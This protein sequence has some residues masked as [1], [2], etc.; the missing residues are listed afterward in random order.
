MKTGNLPKHG[1]ILTRNN[2]NY[3]YNKHS[4]AYICD[5]DPVVHNQVRCPVCYGSNF[6]IS[7]TSP[8]LED[9]KCIANCMCGHEI[10]LHTE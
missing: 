5:P 6:Q 2:I 10:V 4:E 8:L 1:D 3:K 7:F 9:A